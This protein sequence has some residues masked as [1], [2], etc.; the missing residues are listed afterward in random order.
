MTRQQQ[1]RSLLKVIECEMQNKQLWESAPPS[2][3]A[4]SSQQ[5]FCIDTLTFTQ[6]LQW[7]L[8]PRLSALLDG[9]L[10]LPNQSNIS[11]MAEEA[12]KGLSTD[13]RTLLAQ[14]SQLD[15]LLTQPH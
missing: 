11:A 6:W 1:L 4:L 3:A 12:F 9:N 14:L 15:A 13:T 8:L 10:P 7:L 5:P 2:D